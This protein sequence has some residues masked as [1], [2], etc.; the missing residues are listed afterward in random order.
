MLRNNCADTIHAKFTSGPFN[1]LLEQTRDKVQV[2]R[3][4]LSEFEKNERLRVVVDILVVLVKTSTFI[5]QFQR[6]RVI[7]SNVQT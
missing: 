3:N 1:K 4:S 2:S 6:V 5:A 7:V